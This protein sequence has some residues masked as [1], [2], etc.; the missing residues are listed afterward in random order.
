[1]R[2]SVIV[3]V[4]DEERA[5]PA[6]LE[7][8]LQWDCVDEVLFV[9]GG[10]SDSTL[11]LLKDYN[12]V[13]GTRGRG[14]QC[15]LGA[16]RTHGDALVFVHADSTLPNASLRTIREALEGGTRWGCLSLRFDDDSLAMAIGAW[17]SNARVRFT[18]I[19]FGDQVMFMTQDAYEQAGGMP[20]FPLMED[21]ELSRRL[22]SQA[23]PRILPENVTTSARKFTE[24]GSFKT[25][26]EMRRLRRLYRQGADVNELANIYYGKREAAHEQD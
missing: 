26:L 22:R 12:V 24:N 19:A 3:P 9:D 23:W 11:E 25:M 21:Y 7:S 8:A 13:V 6:F 4:L 20:D 5:L 18:G 2:L 15:K 1:M 16:Q 10:S 14:A 17:A